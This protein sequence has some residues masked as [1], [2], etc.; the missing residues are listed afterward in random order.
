LRRRKYKIQSAA[1]L[2]GFS[3]CRGSKGENI[4]GFASDL[5]EQTAEIPKRSRRH[6]RRRR[7]LLAW[8]DE[9]AATAGARSTLTGIA[10]GAVVPI[11]ARCSKG[12]HINST[13]TRHCVAD[14]QGG[15]LLVWV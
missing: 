6:G 10:G 11:V 7:A 3:C 2:P 9:P 14:S 13:L 15:R 8:A 12:G 1:K 4:F 5:F